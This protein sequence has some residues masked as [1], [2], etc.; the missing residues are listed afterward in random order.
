MAKETNKVVEETID[1]TVETVEVAENTEKMIPESQVMDMVRQEI[2]R[3]MKVQSGTPNL[4]DEEEVQEEKM[5]VRISRFDS[6]WVVDYADKNIDPYVKHKVFEFQKKNDISGQVESHVT[7]IF[8]DG[9]EKD[10]PFITYLR[11]R[12]QVKLPVEERVD[13][14]LVKKLGTVTIKEVRGQNTFDTGREIDQTVSRV[15]ST[16]KVDLEGHGVVELP[17]YVIN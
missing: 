13:K 6:K 14:N 5:N 10:V 2:A 3:M 4:D 16:F 1:D 11:N 15:T 9:T 8:A 12:K 7:L 17:A